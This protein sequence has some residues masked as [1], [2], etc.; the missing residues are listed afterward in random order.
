MATS[1][2]T[3][4]GGAAGERPTMFLRKASGVV[5][6]FSPFDSFAYNSLANNPL[7]LAPM[8]FILLAFAFP[9]GNIA[10]GMI[11]AGIFIAVGGVV[12]SMMQAA[13][14]RSGGDYVFQ[15]R[16]LGG[17][18]GFILTFVAYVIIDGLWL[19]LNGWLLTN[20]ILG[21]MFTL[22]GGYWN[23]LWLKDLAAD[24]LIQAA[25]DET[26]DRVT[27]L[28]DKY[29][30]LTLPVVDAEGKLEGAITADD[31]ISVLRQK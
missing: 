1:G 17:S 20:L 25:V 26:Q 31:I 3:P 12:Y 23:V 28:F 30:I 18:V 11:L 6:A 8:G 19:G 2:T 21:P 14:P 9:G 27:E 29:N 16:I 24:T 13:M 10:F 4:N 22:L 15:S 7:T 5:K